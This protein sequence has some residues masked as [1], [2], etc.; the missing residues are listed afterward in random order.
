MQATDI[1]GRA[2]LL[3]PNSQPTGA[4]VRDNLVTDS[5]EGI[6]VGTGNHQVRVQG[7]TA[8][9]NSFNGIRV[10][11]GATQNVLIGNTALDNE[12][13]D[14]RDLDLEVNGHTPTSNVWI[15]TRCVTDLPTGAICTPPARAVSR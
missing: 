14:A 7:N 2:I 11:A 6:A 13:T 4:V 1:P 9:R 10:S 15:G 3:A 12:G 8:L 5:F